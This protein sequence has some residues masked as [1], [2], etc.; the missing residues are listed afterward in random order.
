MEDR[1]LD[2]WHPWEKVSLNIITSRIHSQQ[3]I[4][5]DTYDSLYKNSFGNF[6]YYTKTILPLGNKEN[7][8]SKHTTT[9]VFRKK[10]QKIWIRLNFLLKGLI[11][12]NII[13]CEWA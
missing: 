2:V 13:D 1:A 4:F 3:L 7:Q 9:Q 11:F 12:K 8:K 10:E 5:E 6:R